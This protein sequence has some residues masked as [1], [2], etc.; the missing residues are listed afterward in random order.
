MSRLITQQQAL[1]LAE[2]QVL[3]LQ[4][5]IARLQEEAIHDEGRI[6]HED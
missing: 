3:T 6:V 4:K 1:I 5:R 2:A